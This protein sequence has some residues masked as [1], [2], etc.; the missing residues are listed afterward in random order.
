MN[1]EVEIDPFIS[2][3]DR[4]VEAPDIP[5]HFSHESDASR[6]RLS[7]LDPESLA[8]LLVIED[9]GVECVHLFFR[10]LHNI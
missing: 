5:D 6:K 4:P 7:H 8:V 10:E 1:L 3:S 2:I 9:F